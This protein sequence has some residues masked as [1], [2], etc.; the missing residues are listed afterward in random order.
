MCDQDKTEAAL[1]DAS[2]YIEHGLSL[3]KLPMQ[4]KGY[5]PYSWN[6]RLDLCDL[7][8]SPIEAYLSGL[9]RFPC[10]VRPRQKRHAKPY[11]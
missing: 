9:E 1:Q 4:L 8:A 11:K 3:Y 10:W 6:P 2:I 7:S 5:I